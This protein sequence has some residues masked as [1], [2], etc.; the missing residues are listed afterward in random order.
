MKLLE[1]L[2]KI[3]FVLAPVFVCSVSSY[4][5]IFIFQRLI[6]HSRI[7]FD[8]LGSMSSSHSHFKGHYYSPFQLNDIVAKGKNIAPIIILIK[9]Q[10]LPNFNF[11]A[12]EP[13]NLFWYFF[14][15]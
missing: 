13:K 15:N 3:C 1:H 14:K 12:G 2:G 8:T 6:K 5:L 11:I 7:P 4:F 10:Y 9:I